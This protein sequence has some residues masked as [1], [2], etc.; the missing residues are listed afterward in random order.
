[1][2]KRIKVRF[3]LSAGKNYM[4]WKIEYPDKSPEYYDPKEVQITMRGCQLR[5]QKTTAR[6]IFDGAHKTVCAWVLCDRVYIRSNKEHY[7]PIEEDA[8]Q[9][10]YNPRKHPYW[11][12]GPD[13]NPTN[14]DMLYCHTLITDENKLYKPV[15]I[16]ELS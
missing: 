12:S 10:K 8:T 3:N 11:F 13:H 7:N 16:H 5:N 1:M 14:I 2:T 9:V 4:K 6:K 15:A